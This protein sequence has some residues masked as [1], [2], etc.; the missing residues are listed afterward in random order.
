[1]VLTGLDG[2]EVHVNDPLSGE[3]LTWGKAEFEWMWAGLGHRALA[4]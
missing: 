3:R 4:A 1:V 2:A